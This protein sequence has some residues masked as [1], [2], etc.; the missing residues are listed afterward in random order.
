MSLSED[1]MVGSVATI[2]D[3]EG[4]TKGIREANKNIAEPLK[5]QPQNRPIFRFLLCGIIQY[6]CL[7][8]SYKNILRLG[9]KCILIDI[10][11]WNQFLNF[12]L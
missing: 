12:V 4:E 6:L 2:L 7:I 5:N 9:A 3:H 1:V 8:S 11:F 10:T